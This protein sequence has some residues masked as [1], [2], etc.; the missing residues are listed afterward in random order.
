[1][2][3]GASTTIPHWKGIDGERRWGCDVRRWHLVRGGDEVQSG[4]L[5]ELRWH[6]LKLGVDVEW[7][8]VIWARL[9]TATQQC[10]G[11]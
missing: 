9:P 1:M 10:G 3:R 4:W 11:Q 8:S 2:E 5:G 7:R 6:P